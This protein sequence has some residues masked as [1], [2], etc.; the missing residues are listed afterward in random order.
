LF[1][2]RR[3]FLGLAEVPQYYYDWGYS[4]AYIE[5]MCMDTTIL[6]YLD[7]EDKKQ[8]KLDKIEEAKRI[9]LERKA[10]REKEKQ[11]KTINI[12]LNE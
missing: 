7:E 6:H 2:P 11:Q 10:Q 3:Y 4:K 12:K 9:H 1:A 8:D 5:L